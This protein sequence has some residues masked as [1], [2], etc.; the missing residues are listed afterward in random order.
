METSKVSLSIDA[1]G[2]SCPLPVIRAKKGIESIPLGEVLEVISTDPGS[3]AD[4][5]AWTKA[6]GH[7]LVLAEQSS[8][9]FTYH[10]KRSR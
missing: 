6:T 3:M 8:N 5:K 1:R 10:I 7:E 4:F 9:L 2:L